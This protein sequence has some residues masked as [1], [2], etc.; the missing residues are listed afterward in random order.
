MKPKEMMDRLT[1]FALELSIE[2][3]QEVVNGKDEKLASDATNCAL[4]Q[5]FQHHLC[6]GCPVNEKT[7]EGCAMTPYID[8]EHAQTRS[9]AEKEVKFL[10]S[11]R[12]KR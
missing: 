7:G 2:K 12:K 3:W 1:A 5:I 11:L 9:A 10:K 8:Y 6:K 4:C